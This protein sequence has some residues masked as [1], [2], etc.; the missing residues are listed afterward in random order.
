MT[1]FRALLVSLIAGLLLVPPEGAVRWL[2]GPL[3]AVAALCDRYDG[4]I[5]RRRGEVSA[6]GARLDVAVDALGLLV[7]PLVGVVWH[8]L[9][10]WYLLLGAAYYVFRAGVALRRARGLPVHPE[11]LRP[12]RHARLFAGVQMTVVAAALF[13]FVPPWLTAPAATAAMLPTLAM[14]AREWLIV[15]GRLSADGATEA[16]PE[17]PAGTAAR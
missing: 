1:L 13:P 16:A 4:A 6:L 11:R 10:P 12:N 5:A 9:P 17:A 8:R 3:Y 14:F 15:T 2:P 7:A